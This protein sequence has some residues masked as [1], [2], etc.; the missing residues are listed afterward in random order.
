[1]LGNLSPVAVRHNL[2]A[3]VCIK[4]RICNI[5][6]VITDGKHKLIR[7]KTPFHQIQRQRIRHLLHHQ[8]RALR[9]VGAMQYLPRT[10]AVHL[11][12]VRL[13]LFHRHRLPAPCM[14]DEQLR[15]DAEQP[16]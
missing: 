12:S 15:I 8:P 16:V 11:R 5:F 6:N 14:I 1:M 7:H 10:Y 3:I 9:V 2:S 4:C 13:N